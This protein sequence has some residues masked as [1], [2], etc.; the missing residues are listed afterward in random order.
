MII[1]FKGAHFEWINYNV[2]G[3][4]DGKGHSF[5]KKLATCSLI[6]SLEKPLGLCG[7]FIMLI[8]LG[9]VSQ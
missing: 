3:G 1:I 6:Y 5:W 9:L 4:L 7:L 8:F 2:R